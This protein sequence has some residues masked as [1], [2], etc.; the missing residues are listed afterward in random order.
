[1]S[2]VKNNIELCIYFYQIMMQSITK[3]YYTCTSQVQLSPVHYT[4]FIIETTNSWYVY[5][6]QHAI[7]PPVGRALW[8]GSFNFFDQ[9]ESMDPIKV[10]PII[11]SLSQLASVTYLVR[12]PSS[13]VWILLVLPLY[14]MVS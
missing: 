14:Q 6:S 5:K 2:S 8:I 4:N 1:M 3:F 12:T 9:I 7:I 10:N 13:S 11:S